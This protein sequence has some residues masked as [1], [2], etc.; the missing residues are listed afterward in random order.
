MR[1]EVAGG[2]YVNLFL[3]RGAFAARPRSRSLAEAAGRA[4]APRPRHRRAHEHQPQQGRPHRPPAQ[5]L[6]RR[7][8]RAPAAPPRLRRRGA[9]LHRRHRRAGGR[10]GGGLPAHR[11]EVARRGGADRRASSTTTAGTSTRGW[12]TSTRPTRSARRCRPRPSTR[13][14][15]GGN[16]TARLGEHVARADR[17]LPPRHDGAARDPLRPARPRERHPAAALL[18]PRLRAAEGEGRHPPGDRGQ[19]R[20]LLGAADGRGR[21]GGRST[22]TRSSSARTAPS[23]TPA[24]TSPTSCGSSASSTATSATACT[25]RTPDGHAAVDH[26]ERRGRA[27]RAR[28]SATPTAVYNVIDVGQSYPQRVVKAGVAALGYAEAA[29]GSH[30]LAYEKVV[31]S[32]ATARALGY[33][34]SEDETV[35][36]GLGPQGPRGQGRRPAGRAGGEGAGRGRRPRPRSATRRAARRPPPRSPSARCAT[37]C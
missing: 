18:G 9:E 15:Q 31:L 30:H 8:L 13:S 16:D 5:R 36:Q 34:V 35:G 20:G 10:R 24:R 26:H 6:P 33:D 4:A 7:H 17:R 37:S 32:P 3:D 11:E 22:R 23:P 14:R 12:A 1:A 28:A 19:E 21:R 25:G 27:G 2:G 29:E